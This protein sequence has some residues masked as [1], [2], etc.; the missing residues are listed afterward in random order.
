MSQPHWTRAF[1]TRDVVSFDR[2]ISANLMSDGD[3]AVVHV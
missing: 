2:T 3:S 1:S